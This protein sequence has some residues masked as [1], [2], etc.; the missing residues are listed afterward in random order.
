MDQINLTSTVNRDRDP[1]F[2]TTDIDERDPE[3]SRI[4]LFE[5]G[6]GLYRD[7]QLLRT[8]K[9]LKDP[10]IKPGS[11]VFFSDKDRE[12]RV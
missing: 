8:Q 10:I 1:T 7:L 3:L 4:N 11:N 5:K 12:G 2:R 6:N 9:F